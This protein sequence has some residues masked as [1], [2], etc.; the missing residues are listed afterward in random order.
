MKTYGD[1][2]SE[3]PR[4]V[5]LNKQKTGK[6]VEVH[7]NVVGPFNKIFDR[8]LES[9]KKAYKLAAKLKLKDEHAEIEK[10]LVDAS[11]GKTRYRIRD[12]KWVEK[13]NPKF[14]DIPPCSSVFNF[15]KI[16][17]QRK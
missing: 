4:A 16:E 14:N 1:F 8:K 15:K 5:V 11:G 9:P 17:L 3:S 12:R 10:V 6:N 13:K 7:Y 2:M